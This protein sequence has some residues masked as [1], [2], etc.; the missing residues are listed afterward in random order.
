M[1]PRHGSPRQGRSGAVCPRGRSLHRQTARA[2][3]ARNQARARGRV[4]GPRRLPIL[5]R[6]RIARRRRCLAPHPHHSHGLGARSGRGRHRP[7][8]QSQRQEPAPLSSLGTCARPARQHRLSAHQGRLV[9]RLHELPRPRAQ[10]PT[11]LRNT[12]PATRSTHRCKCP[13]PSSSSS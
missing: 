11:A 8:R 5:E 3:S 7:L 9:L 10:S 12:K 4:A 2:L 13:I 1:G 6:R